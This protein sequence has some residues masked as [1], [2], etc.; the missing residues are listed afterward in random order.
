[1]DKSGQMTEQ[2]NRD[3]VLSIQNNV[4]FDRESISHGPTSWK[5]LV[6]RENCIF[7]KVLMNY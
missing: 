3:N 6:L 1:M 2:Q 4:V 7:R 5:I